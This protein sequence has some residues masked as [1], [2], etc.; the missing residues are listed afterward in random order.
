MELGKCTHPLSLLA[1]AL[2][3]RIWRQA[4][5]PITRLYSWDEGISVYWNLEAYK[6]NIRDLLV[7]NDDETAIWHSCLDDFLDYENYN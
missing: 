2:V 3:A 4:T 1:T 6:K 7:S 5:T